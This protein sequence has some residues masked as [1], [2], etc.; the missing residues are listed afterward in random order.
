M[1]K[2]DI[3]ANEMEACLLLERQLVEEKRKTLR[4]EYEAKF[5]RHELAESQRL[6]PIPEHESSL[7]LKQRKPAHTGIHQQYAYSVPTP[8]LAHTHWTRVF[9]NG[10]S[11]SP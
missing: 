8:S 11:D 1:R 3:T 4:L 6:A 5:R 10:S 7:G 9:A 2:K